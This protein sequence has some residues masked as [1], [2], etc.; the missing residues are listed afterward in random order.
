MGGSGDVRPY[1]R[2]RTRDTLIVTHTALIMNDKKE[3]AMSN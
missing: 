1:L 2:T 3:A